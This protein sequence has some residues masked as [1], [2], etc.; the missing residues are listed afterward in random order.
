MTDYAIPIVWPNYPIAAGFGMVRGLGHAGVVIVDGSTGHTNYFEYGRYERDDSGNPIGVVKTRAVPNLSINDGVI[1]GNS[2]NSLIVSLNAS[3]GKDTAAVGTILPLSNRGYDDALSYAQKALQDPSGTV[4]E[5]SWANDTHCYSFAK[6]VAAAGGSWLDWFDGLG[7][8]DNVPSTAMLELITQY[9]GFTIGGSNDF[10]TGRA[11]KYLSDTGFD[12][13]FL[14]GTPILLADGTDKPIEDITVGD[15]V[16]SYDAAGELVANRVSKVFRNQSKHILDVFGLMIT[17]G[18]V[19]Y[20]ADGPFAGQHV[21]MLDI[22]RSDGALMKSDGTLVRAA[23][24]CQVGSK[25]DALL[26]VVTGERQPDGNV[27]IKEKAQIRAGSRFILDD[28]RDIC[29]LDL[30][31]AAEGELTEDGYIKLAGTETP[32]PFHWIFSENLPA[33]ED[34]VLQ[35]SQ[36]SLPEIYRAAEWEGKQPALPVDARVRGRSL[37]ARSAEENVQ[38]KPNVPLSLRSRPN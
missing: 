11:S 23:T 10:L 35:R 30:I 31:K 29:L 2:L 18:H 16:Q 32:L 28:G 7:P 27:A 20:C 21:T 12:K 37:T 5:Y 1:D 8:F 19:T 6:S 26:W 3:A 14:A 22:L 17:P 24:G 36:V 34:Y 25:K 15:I 33:P 9:G 13:C 38:G 4:G